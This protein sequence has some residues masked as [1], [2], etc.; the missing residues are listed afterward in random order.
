[1]SETSDYEQFP[2]SCLLN[3]VTSWNL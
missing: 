2:D 1:M 3:L